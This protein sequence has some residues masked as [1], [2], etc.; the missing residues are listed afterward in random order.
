MPGDPNECRRHALNCL[1]LA[2]TALTPE[3]RE[4]FYKLAE[5]WTNLAAE[6]ESTQS[7]LKTMV[8]LESEQPI[9]APQ[10]SLEN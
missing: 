6:L 10:R 9:G 1:Q 3:A 4:H 7:F 5:T 2:E 8:E